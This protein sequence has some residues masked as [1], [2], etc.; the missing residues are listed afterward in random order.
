MNNSKIIGHLKNYIEMERQKEYD[1]LAFNSFL[2]F[3]SY[4]LRTSPTLKQFILISPIFKI[5]T[6]EEFEVIS[7]IDLFGI[8]SLNIRDD[9]S[10]NIN[11][12]IDLRRVA[13]QIL[14]KFIVNSDLEL[15]TIVEMKETIRNLLNEKKDI[16]NFANTVEEDLK[17]LQQKNSILKMLESD[18][19]QLE[20][21]HIRGIDVSKFYRNVGES[22]NLTLKLLIQESQYEAYRDL[23]ISSRAYDQSNHEFDQLV[24]ELTVLEFPIFPSRDILK[25]KID[26]IKLDTDFVVN[27]QSVSFSEEG[28]KNLEN[29]LGDLFKKYSDNINLLASAFEFLGSINKTQIESIYNFIQIRD[30]DK[31]QKQAIVFYLGNNIY[32]FELSQLNNFKTFQELSLMSKREKTEDFQEFY[33]KTIDFIFEVKNSNNF[34][35]ESSMILSGIFTNIL[36]TMNA[37]ESS[38]INVSKDISES[39]DSLFDSD[40]FS[41]KFILYLAQSLDEDFNNIGLKS[42]N[43]GEFQKTIKLRIENR[44]STVNSLI[45]ILMNLNEKDIYRF[46]RVRGAAHLKVIYRDYSIHQ[47]FSDHKGIIADIFDKFY[48]LGV[49]DINEGER[50]GIFDINE[51]NKDTLLEKITDNISIFLSKYNLLLDNLHLKGLSPDIVNIEGYSE[52]DKEDVIEYFIVSQELLQLIQQLGF[53]IELNSNKNILI[54][55]NVDLFSDYLKG[56]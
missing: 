39:K 35:I 54:K 42:S 41:S 14:N 6:K 32:S 52:S 46:C 36:L 2:H 24:D 12:L 13:Y 19:I 43:V 17:S 29:W 8:L 25:S 47:K 56:W 55:L 31:T 21:L 34:N 7:E 4:T 44:L 3:D 45:N 30:L 51:S 50:L 40:L 48:E 9:E 18:L 49:S 23:W 5:L 33:N 11:N 27:D 26:T 38:G 20:E 37:L 15:F 10:L 16:T 28:V 1:Q 22:I 53:R